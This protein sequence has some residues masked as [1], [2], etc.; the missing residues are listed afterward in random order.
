MYLC[1][2]HMML[3][4]FFISNTFI[5]KARLKLAKNHTSAMQHPEAGVLL[6]ESYLCSSS[7]LSSKNIRT[8]S[9]KWAKNNCVCIHEITRLTIMKMKMKMKNRSHN[10]DLDMDTKIAL[11]LGMD[12]KI[13]NIESV[14]VWWCLYVLRNT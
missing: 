11:N 13:G 4:T 2:S 6:F 10:L 12:T 14:S 8:Y 9:K 5:R 7:S 3:H 1:H